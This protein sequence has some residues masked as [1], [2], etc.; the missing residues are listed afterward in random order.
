LRRER[1][2]DLLPPPAVLLRDEASPRTLLLR[3]ERFAL[4]VIAVR[5]KQFQQEE[6]VWKGLAFFFLRFVVTSKTRKNEIERSNG[7]LGSPHACFK[8]A[9]KSSKYNQWPLSIDQVIFFLLNRFL[10][11]RRLAFFSS[12][13]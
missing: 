5:D 12:V 9:K 11:T 8:F 3:L 4:M 1:D 2:E 7:L 6:E 10:L 13:D